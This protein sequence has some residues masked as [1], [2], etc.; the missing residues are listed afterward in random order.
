MDTQTTDRIV[1]ETV[2]Q[3]PLSRVWKAISDAQEF[4][5]WFKVDMSGQSFR[6]GQPVHAR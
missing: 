6:P 5:E 3:A 1:K 4:G 2:L